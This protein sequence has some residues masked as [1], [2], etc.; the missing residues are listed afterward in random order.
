MKKSY[1]LP[2]T[3]NRKI[4]RAMHDYS[5]LSDNDRVLV[6]VS[7]GIDSM[8]LC[9]IMKLWQHKAPIRFDLEA[10]HIDHGFWKTSPQGEGPD[11]TIGDQLRERGI[12]FEIVDEWEISGSPR[13]CFLCSRNRRSQLFDLCRKRNYTKIALGHHK[14]DLIETFML[15]A[16]YSG[17]ISTMV[18]RQKLFGGTLSIVRPM[19]YLD[20]QDIGEIAAG[21]Q[22][23]PVKNLCLLSGDSRREKVRKILATLYEDEPG[24]RASLFAALANVRKDYLL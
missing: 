20:K 21:L 14:D 22:L 15:N 8:V 23:R 19:A 7:G 18:P 5:M 2:A 9:C 24:A 10:I 4:G 16:I 6:A 12:T 11:R 13:S 17:N 3:M 1:T